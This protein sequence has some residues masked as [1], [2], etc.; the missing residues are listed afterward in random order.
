MPPFRDIKWG[1]AL[2]FENLFTLEDPPKNYGI[3]LGM[4]P[5]ILG[6]VMREKAQFCRKTKKSEFNE[7]EGLTNPRSLAIHVGKK[8]LSFWQ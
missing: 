1:L 3:E 8:A 6:V 4:F 2:I 7:N 5:K